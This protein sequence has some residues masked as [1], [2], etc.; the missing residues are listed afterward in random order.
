MRTVRN[1]LNEKGYGIWYTTPDTLVFDALK[2]MAKKDIGALLVLEDDELV[3]VF[4]ERDYARKVILR[5]KSSKQIQVREIMNHRLIT[6]GIDQTVKNALALM[7]QKHIRHLP[8]M[9]G[10]RLVGIVSIG[11]LVN[12]IIAEQNELI[13]KLE[14]YILKT[15]SLT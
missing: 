15:T 14:G 5:G 7:N 6:V 13:D 3:G 8:V 11:D 4:S 12:A 9:E 10:D 2:I 1:L